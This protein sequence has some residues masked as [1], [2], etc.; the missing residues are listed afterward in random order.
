MRRKEVSSNTADIHLLRDPQY[1]DTFGFKVFYPRFF[2]WSWIDM[3][4]MVPHQ[5]DNHFGVE[6]GVVVHDYDFYS[7]FLAP[8]NNLVQKHICDHFRGDFG[9]FKVIF[10]DQLPNFITAPAHV[11]YSFGI[12]VHK[13]NL[14]D[15]LCSQNYL[16]VITESTTV[17][18]MRTMFFNLHGLRLCTIV[19]V[20]IIH[21]FVLPERPSKI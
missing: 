10:E 6:F 9:M 11:P 7:F 2:A 8:R 19:K 5:R 13:L 3:N 17:H 20:V 4:S 1:Q 14:K 16:W 18:E 21:H 12:P 15:I